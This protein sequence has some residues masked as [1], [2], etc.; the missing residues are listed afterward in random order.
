MNSTVRKIFNVFCVVLLFSF[1]SYA[2]DSI[3][4][5]PAEST[6]ST[7]RVTDDTAKVICNII[8][9]IWGIGGPLMTVVII[10]ASLLAIFG[11]MAWPALFALGMFCG[12]FFGAKSIVI[13]IIP[14]V[15]DEMSTM[16]Q[17]CG[18]NNN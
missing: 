16:L 14:Y 5:P 9:Y 10:G 4:G 18:K 2:T 12:V 17:D 8:G 6:S 15:N 1:S 3:A 7:S 11:R 13:K